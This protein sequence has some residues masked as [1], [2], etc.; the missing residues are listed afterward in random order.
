MDRGKMFLLAAVA[1]VGLG[2]YGETVDLED[3]RVQEREP[4]TYYDYVI[5]LNPNVYTLKEGHSVVVYITAYD[6]E[7]VEELMKKEHLYHY[8]VSV[9]QSSVELILD[10]A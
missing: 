4:G 3:M 1:A 10:L 6:T 8:D 2:Y 7:D 9:D 5:D